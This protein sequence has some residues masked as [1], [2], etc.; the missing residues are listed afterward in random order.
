MFHIPLSLA[1]A[2]AGCS[3]FAAPSPS[4]DGGDS[5]L[6]PS[7]PPRFGSVPLPPPL[8][9]DGVSVPSCSWAREESAASVEA[10]KAEA[11]AV[12]SQLEKS[13]TFT[14]DADALRESLKNSL[15]GK[16]LG[17]PPPIAL[18]SRDVQS[19]DRISVIKL[20]GGF[21]LFRFSDSCGSEAPMMILT[22]GP[23]NLGG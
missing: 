8:L 22:E 7:S 18:I 12:L 23:W 1:L 2:A 16:F 17:R 20:A 9:N 6:S 13:G 21:F 5:V 15:I 11:A 3:P 14:P 10:F 4:Y 19:G